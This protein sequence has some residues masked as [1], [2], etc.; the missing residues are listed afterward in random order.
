[1]HQSQLFRRLL[2]I[3]C[4]CLVAFA[5]GVATAGARAP[6]P[7]CSG[8]CESLCQGHDGCQTFYVDVDI[9]VYWCMDGYHDEVIMAK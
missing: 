3:A 6:F 4:S 2:I 8:I 7:G 1:M 9:C 5:L